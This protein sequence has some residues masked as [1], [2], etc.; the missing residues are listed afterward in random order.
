MRALQFTTRLYKT[1]WLMPLVM[2]AA[3][4]TPVDIE[5]ENKQFGAVVTI[6][7][8]ISNQEDRST[9]EVG[10]AVEESTPLPVSEAIVSVKDQSG[11]SYQFF[12]DPL[13]PGRYTWGGTGIPGVQYTLEVVLPDGR[14]F[15][16]QTETMTTPASPDVVSY[17]FKVTEYVDFE[18]AII[19][20]PRVNIFTKPDFTGPKR[21]LVRWSVEEAYLLRPTNFPDPFGYQPPDCF[22]RQPADPQRV[23]L[24]DGRV[25]SG[26]FPEPLLI[27]TR[28]ID[29]S[30]FYR[31]Y[32]S[33]YQSSL[34]TTAYDY[35]N[36]V[37]ILTNQTGSI[38][39]VPPARIIGNISQEGKPNVKALGFFQATGENLSRFYIVQSELPD[40]AYR[41]SFCDYDPY[42]YS[43]YPEECLNCLTVRNST[44]RRP[45][46]F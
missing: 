40:Y 44:L 32:F 9:V 45:W 41:P 42:R 28:K 20:E 38:F 18:G 17:E 22:V 2:A 24:F 7:G 33:V 23:T 4:L 19:S 14:I 34:T 15:R 31:H 16:S 1:S 11:N 43:P 36:K 3:C 8:Q 35:W 6:S 10:V 39:D 12:E 37:D 21:P 25:Y 29:Q 5:V 27:A 46:W 26:K 30:F 13:F